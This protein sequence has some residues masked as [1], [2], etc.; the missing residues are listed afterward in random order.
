MKYTISM[1]VDGRVDMEVEA[2][3]LEEAFE[4]AR[5]EGPSTKEMKKMEVIDTSPVNAT[6]EN[7]EL[8][9]YNG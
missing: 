9:D 3:S 5:C 1:K 4:I 6:D 8:H 2:D 7:G